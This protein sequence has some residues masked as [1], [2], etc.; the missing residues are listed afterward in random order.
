MLL[1]PQ[2]SVLEASEV[3]NSNINKKNE[4]KNPKRYVFQH[5]MTVY[6]IMERTKK[7]GI[8]SLFFHYNHP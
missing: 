7:E 3:R 2:A 8:N 5:K 6:T 1:F 4:M